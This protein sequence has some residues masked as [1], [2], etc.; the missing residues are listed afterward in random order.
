MPSLNRN[1]KVKCED[2]DKE[3]R[4][5]MSYFCPE[6]NYCTYN[7]YEARKVN[8]KFKIICENEFP[9]YYSLQQHRRKHHALNARKTSDSVADLNQIFENDE[10]SDQL[11]DELNA[12]QPF[13]RDTEMEKGV[14]VPVFK[15]RS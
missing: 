4:L 8:P 2:R 7:K 13:L 15:I 14:Q 6:C 10:D 1:E 12:S 3:Y 5:A 11:R 9:S